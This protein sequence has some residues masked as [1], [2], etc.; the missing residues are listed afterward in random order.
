MLTAHQ[1]VIDYG[2]SE[3]REEILSGIGSSRAGSN[4]AGRTSNSR[5]Y[6][7]CSRDTVLAAETDGGPEVE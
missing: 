4:G 1:G 3:H 2:P 5:T 7:H 6:G